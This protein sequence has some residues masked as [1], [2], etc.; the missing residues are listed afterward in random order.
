VGP[1]ALRW[2]WEVRAEVLL[3]LPFALPIGAFL[4][5]LG[6]YVATLVVE[7]DSERST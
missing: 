5:V 4:L 2:L 3:V 6:L 7:S 1:L